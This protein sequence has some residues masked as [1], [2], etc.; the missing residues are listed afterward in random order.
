MEFKIA[1]KSW[2]L[3]KET[4]NRTGE[5]NLTLHSAAIAFYAIF[6]TAP[7]LII[8][9]WVVGLIWGG[10]A[11]EEELQETVEMITG[12]EVAGTI[13]SVVEASAG[14]G[15]GVISSVIAILTLLFGATTLLAQIKQ[16]LNVIWGIRNPELSSIWQ[17]FWDR[18]VS[19]LFIGLLS[20]LFILGLASESILYGMSDL[21][22]PILGSQ[23]L[24]F[25]QYLSSSLNVVLA[26]SFLTVLFKVLPDVVVRWRDIAVGSAV[27]TILVLAGKTLIDWYLMASDLQHAYQAAGSFVIFLIWVYYNVL[28]ILVGAIFTQVYTSRFGGNIRT[29][30][31]ATLFSDWYRKPEE[32]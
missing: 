25:L 4:Y 8:L 3:V 20:L 30:W 32:S 13:Q 2:E 19:L 26:F 12:P 10:R 31:N 16:S 27:T 18:L 17:F 23:Q 6:S 14:N 15:T 5:I 29:Y 1:K 21:L 28:V 9:F 22:I 24:L 7:L 11:G